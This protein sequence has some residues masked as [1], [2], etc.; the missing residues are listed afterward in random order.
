MV[1]I[2]TLFT[3]GNICDL[4]RIQFG[5]YMKKVIYYLEI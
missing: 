4:N 3:T 2:K 1:I 5:K